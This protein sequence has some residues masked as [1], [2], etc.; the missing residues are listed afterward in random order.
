[1]KNDP[2]ATARGSVTEAV[3]VFIIGCLSACRFNKKGG[4]RATALV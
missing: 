2:V 3:I 1:M 4:G